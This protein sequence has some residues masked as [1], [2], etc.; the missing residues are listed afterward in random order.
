MAASAAFF[1]ALDATASAGLAARAAAT[2][3][4]R[5]STAAGA[6][7][8]VMGRSSRRAPG[9]GSCGGSPAPRN[10]Y[11]SLV[12]PSRTSAPRTIW[13]REVWSEPL[14]RSAYI[15]A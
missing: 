11:S 10:S 2:W 14:G 15:P 5:A 8:V 9:Q 3:A 1:P 6:V 7:V 13:M 4:R 12:T